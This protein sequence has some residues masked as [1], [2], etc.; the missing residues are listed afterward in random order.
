M[1]KANS[2]PAQTVSC[3]NQIGETAGAVWKTLDKHGSMSLAKLVERV[4]GN[5]DV[6]MQAIG[7]LAR[8]DKLE[9]SETSRGR[10]ITLKRETAVV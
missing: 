9:I 8:E 3:V 7:W 6:V 4:G 10:T 5:R 1:A 2:A